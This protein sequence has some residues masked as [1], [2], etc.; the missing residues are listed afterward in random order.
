MAVATATHQD[1]AVVLRAPY[2]RTLWTHCHLRQ[3]ARL[4]DIRDRGR[5][6]RTAGLMALSFHEP[7]KLSQEHQRLL[8]SLNLD[9]A[10]SVDDARA[11]ALALVADVAKADSAGGWK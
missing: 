1:V 7:W 2:H 9:S 4:D 11:R 10:E 6:L 5:E 3:R 8:S